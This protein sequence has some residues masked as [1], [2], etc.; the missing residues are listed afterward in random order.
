MT[1]PLFVSFFTPQ[2]EQEAASLIE[3]LKAF[4]L[5]HEVI[6]RK[7]LGDWYQNTRMKPAV[8]NGAMLHHPGR[9]VVWLDS[10]ARVRRRPELFWRLACDVAA[11]R[12]VHQASGIVEYLSGTVYLSGSPRSVEFASRW[13]AHCQFRT[14]VSEQFGFN[15]ALAEAIRDTSFRFE[16]LPVEYTFVFDRHRAEF[17]GV[18]PVIEHFQK[19]RETRGSSL[20]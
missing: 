17:P 20:L 15:D 2:Y 5:D 16:P 4:S 14:D 6:E 3:T 9:P 7:N 1:D 12:T 19:S 11:Y 13:I 8:V 10:D 18:K